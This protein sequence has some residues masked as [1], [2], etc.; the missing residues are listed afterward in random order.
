MSKQPITFCEETIKEKQALEVVW[1]DLAKR[2]KA[3]RDGALYSGR[4]ENFEEFLNDPAMDMDK[5][6]A[7][8]MISIH[9]KLVLEYQIA[10]KTIAL[11]GGWSKISEVLHVMDSKK[12]AEKWLDK[13]SVLSKSDLRKEIQEAKHGAPNPECKH[14]NTYTIEICRDCGQ[15][16]E[17]HKHDH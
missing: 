7:S 8:K 13:C 5:G 2:L 15:K 11:S 4:W 6:T 3:I 14:K 16:I 9:E 12:E 17:D 10:P 1:L